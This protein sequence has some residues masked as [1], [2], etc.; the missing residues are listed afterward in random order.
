MFQA[1]VVE[2]IK[3]HFIFNNSIFDNCT[4]YEIM[5][6]D[7]VEWGRSEMTT[8]GMSTACWITKVTDTHSEYVIFIASLQQQRLC[9]QTSVLCYT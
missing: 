4:I 3:T 6:K 7:I 2:K 8:R 9:K 5:W 1:K